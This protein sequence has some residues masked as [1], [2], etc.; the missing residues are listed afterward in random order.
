MAGHFRQLIAKKY[1][2]LSKDECLTDSIRSACENRGKKYQCSNIPGSF[3]CTCRDGF[4]P[5]GSLPTG[6]VSYS[7]TCGDKGKLISRFL[8]LFS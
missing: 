3:R 4:V 7:F 5:T 6:V 2:E 1:L 8:Q